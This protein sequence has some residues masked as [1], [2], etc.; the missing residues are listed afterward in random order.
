M[1]RAPA[2]PIGSAARWGAVALLLVLLGITIATG[3]GTFLRR[4]PE[5]ALRIA[6]WDA[7][8][9]GRLSRDLLL[10]GKAQADRSATLARKAL[11]RDPTVVAAVVATG[12]LAEM[13]GKKAAATDRFT[14]AAWLSRRDMP[15]QMWWIEHSVAG[16]DIAAALHHY[17]IALRA[18]RQAPDVLFPILGSAIGD[19]AIRQGLV[20]VLKADPSWRDRFFEWLVVNG[21][22]NRPTAMILSALHGARRPIASDLFGRLEQRLIDQKDYDGAWNFYRQRHSGARRDAA[23]DTDF[24]AAAVGRQSPFD[25]NVPAE[26]GGASIG[27]LQGRTVLTFATVPTNA[28]T[29]ARQFMLLPPGNYRLEADAGLDGGNPASA[30]YW[31]LQCTHDQRELGRVPLNARP[32]PALTVPAGCPAQ[33]LVLR[34]DAGDTTEGATGIVRMVRL[35]S[36]TR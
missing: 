30:P 22:N 13:Q 35:V 36:M 6:P 28:A 26:E 33:W 29:L 7:R 10:Q 17:D 21:V 1:A 32:S 15:T 31:S 5:I 3:A 14:Y 2:L 18:I 20:P 24:A 12:L 19:P 34:N 9:A 11:A 16:D 8:L 4:T 27:Q 25:W 23:N